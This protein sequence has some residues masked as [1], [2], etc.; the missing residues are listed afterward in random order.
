[1]SCPR[2]ESPD[3][4]RGEREGMEGEGKP[5]RTGKAREGRVKKEST[6]LR[7]TVTSCA[8]TTDCYQKL[9]FGPKCGAFIKLEAYRSA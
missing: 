8:V 3:A 2:A 6:D 5:K 9:P 7:N 4:K 1:M